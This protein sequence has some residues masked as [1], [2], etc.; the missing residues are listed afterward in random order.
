MK[1]Q[2]AQSLLWR[3]IFLVALIGVPLEYAMSAEPTRVFSV[4]T[5]VKRGY[6]PAVD[7]SLRLGETEHHYWQTSLSLVGESQGN[8]NNAAVQG[9]YVAKFGRLDVGLGAALLQ[10]VDGYNGSH[11]N[12]AIQVGYRMDGWQ[13]QWRHWS[14]AGTKLPNLGR[15]LLWVGRTF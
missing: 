2:I 11:A 5:A 6:A 3:L 9:L 13:A 14:N 4:G 1:M 10:N 15:D 12:F 8:G 7:F